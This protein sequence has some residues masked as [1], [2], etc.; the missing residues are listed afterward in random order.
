[1]DEQTADF[2]TPV[3]D[4]PAPSQEAPVEGADMFAPAPVEGADMF[5][6][7]PVPVEG[8]YENIG[9]VDFAGHQEM[10]DMHHPPAVLVLDEPAPEGDSELY[11]PAPQGGEMC[12]IPGPPPQTDF[13]S[14][15]GEEYQPAALV[16]VEGE[17]EI[18]PM[19]KFNNEWQVILR[20]RKDAENEMKANVVNQARDALEAFQA[21]KEKKKEMRMAKNRSDEQQKLEDIEAD[22]ENDNSWQRVV[23]MVE[24]QQDTVEGA[25]DNKRM[26]DVLI[27]MKNN[28]DRALSLS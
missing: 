9:D 4:A 16:E 3:D 19:A 10:G 1:M 2:F 21:E 15:E 28:T 18:S 12:I 20:E 14:P 26:I 17:K 5:A 22:L 23:K 11:A 8:G 13:M 27:N 24:L 6:A 7:A 25:R